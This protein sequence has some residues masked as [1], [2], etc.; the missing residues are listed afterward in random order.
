MLLALASHRAPHSRKRFQQLS[1]MDFFAREVSCRVWW[2]WGVHDRSSGG[3]R[4]AKRSPA[5][6]H[7][8]HMKQRSK[9][10]LLLGCLAAACRSAWSLSAVSPWQGG[11]AG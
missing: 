1:M 10:R 6:R 8:T 3:L 4:K 5:H 2:V 7:I 9:S 11:A